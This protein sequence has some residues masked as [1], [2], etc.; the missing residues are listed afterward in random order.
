MGILA[1]LAVGFW[2]Q[3][4]FFKLRKVD[5]IFIPRMPE[6]FFQAG[7]HGLRQPPYPGITQYGQSLSVIITGTQEKFADPH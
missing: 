1:G 6:V 4:E 7:G 5:R 3:D 2:T